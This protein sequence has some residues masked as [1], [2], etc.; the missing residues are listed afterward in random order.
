MPLLNDSS[1]TYSMTLLEDKLI[2]VINT[3][4]TTE[5]HYYMDMC[6]AACSV[7]PTRPYS[8]I[9]PDNLSVYQKD[10]KIS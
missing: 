1:E 9:R 8:T 3:A 10:T 2:S 5:H 4:K 7:H 6:E